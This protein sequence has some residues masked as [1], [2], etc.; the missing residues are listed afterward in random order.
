MPDFDDTE[1]LTSLTDY[2]GI[3]TFKVDNFYY[4]GYIK[5]TKTLKSYILRDDKKDTIPFYKDNGVRFLGEIA[6]KD[7][8]VTSINQDGKEK[9]LDPNN[10]VNQELQ[11]LVYGGTSF[12]EN[13]NWLV[14]NDNGK[15]KLVS[16]KPLKH[17]IAWNTLYN[18]GVVF[19]EDGVKDLVNADFT[20]SY[21]KN[22]SSPSRHL[23]DYGKDKGTSKTYK[24]TYITINNKKYVVRLMRAYNENAEI[25]DN[26]LWGSWNSNTSKSYAKGSE[27]NR[28]LLP[29]IDPTGDDNETGYNQGTNGRYGSNTE[30]FVESNMPTLANYSLWTDFGGNNNSSGSYDK[31][32]YYGIYRWAQETGFDGSKYRA[33]R[34]YHSSG[35]AA[36]YAT[37]GYP[38]RDSSYRGWLAVLERVE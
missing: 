31:G 27:W 33:A 9:E 14:F 24:P 1:Y 13:T 26:K 7:M 25:N 38:S 29:L 32:K 3:V 4:G 16:K 19:G 12:N 8:K 6:P 21:Y 28:L 18:A 5:E 15:E 23:K 36:A 22:S 17:S 10:N 34:G 2:N 37:S 20:G 11:K 30:D 35:N